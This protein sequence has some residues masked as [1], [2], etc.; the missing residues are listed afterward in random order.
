[1]AFSNIA[2]QNQIFSRSASNFGAASQG[3]LQILYGENCGRKEQ[4]NAN[5]LSGIALQRKGEAVEQNKFVTTDDPVDEFADC[6]CHCSMV[7]RSSFGVRYLLTVPDSTH[8][9][10]TVQAFIEISPLSHHNVTA[11]MTL[12]LSLFSRPVCAA[13]KIEG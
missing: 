1:L 3:K 9:K 6:V 11:T 12:R 7:L 8:T 10:L 13:D 4:R 2:L 5:P